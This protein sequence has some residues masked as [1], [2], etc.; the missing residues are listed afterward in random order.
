MIFDMF[1]L[2]ELKKYIKYHKNLNYYD[3]DEGDYEDEE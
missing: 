3:Y 1:T 2:E